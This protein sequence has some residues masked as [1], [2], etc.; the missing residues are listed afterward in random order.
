MFRNPPRP[1]TLVIPCPRLMLEETSDF[2]FC[3]PAGKDAGGKRESEV[4]SVLERLPD[5]VGAGT[6]NRAEG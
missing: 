2:N 1:C 3:S 4:E 5:D 6:E